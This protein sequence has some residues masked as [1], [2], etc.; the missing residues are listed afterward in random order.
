MNLGGDLGEEGGTVV[1]GRAPAGVQIL[2]S[3]ALGDAE[4]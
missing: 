2:D 3:V 1:S 4:P